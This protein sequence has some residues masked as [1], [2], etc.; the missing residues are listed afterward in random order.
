MF[1]TYSILN[2]FNARCLQLL[3]NF[4]NSPSVMVPSK[5]GLVMDRL[6]VLFRKFFDILT[7]IQAFLWRVLELHILK[8]VALF[9]IWVALS[10]V[11]E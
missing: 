5:W 10:E 2:I 9:V 11:S 7:H 4:L 8:I 1:W 6:M 3:K